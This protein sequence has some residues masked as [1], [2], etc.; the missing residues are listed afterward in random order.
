MSIIVSGYCNTSVEALPV[1]VTTDIQNDETVDRNNSNTIKVTLWSYNPP[2]DPGPTTISSNGSFVVVGT[3]QDDNQGSVYFLNNDG[4]VVWSSLLSGFVKSVNISPD[5]KFVEARTI[6]ILN[7]GGTDFGYNEWDA[8]PDMYIFDNAGNV[9][10]HNLNL[11]PTWRSFSPSNSQSF[12]VTG[13]DA[14]TSYSDNL[15][16]VLSKYNVTSNVVSISVSANGSFTAACTDI[17]IFFFDRQGTLLWNYK[18]NDPTLCPNIDSTDLGYVLAGQA[19]SNSTGNL[20]L[21]DKDGHLLWRHADIPRQ[22]DLLTSQNYVMSSDGQYAVEVTG[23]S[24]RGYGLTVS[25]DKIRYDS[26]VPEFSFAMPILVISISSLIIFHRT[27]F[28]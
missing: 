9:I 4:I 25:Y 1:S 17:G 23:Q 14:S 27:K 20:Y 3:R 22:E 24:N 11:L 10:Y 26:T 7:N 13:T 2:S 15:G 28:R 19:L 6:Q 21:F 5:G 12:S 16:K 18:T 8:N